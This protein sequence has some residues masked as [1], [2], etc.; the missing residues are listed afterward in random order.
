MRLACHALLIA[1]MAIPATP[2]ASAQNDFRPV[3]QAAT[4]PDFFTFRTQ[5]QVAIA[6]C[7]IQALLAV[8]HKDIKNSFG[9]TDGV[10]E[11]KQIWEL[12]KPGTLIWETLARVL[13]LG[14]SLDGD[15]R[16][17]AP[18]VFSRWPSGVDPC[19]FVAI[20]GTGV[21]VRTEPT[22]A[23]ESLTSLSFEI[24]QEVQTQAPSQKWVAIAM[25]EGEACQIGN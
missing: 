16:F 8:V 13:A 9:G 14:G 10:D 11:F 18:Y 2:A 7:D 20:V 5:L 19:G 24:V 22:S 15:D 17:V 12:D 25:R 3:D 6:R 21:P 23:A 4:Q 1:L